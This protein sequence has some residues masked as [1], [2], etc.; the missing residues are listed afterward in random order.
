MKNN[1]KN[2][3]DAETLLCLLKMS[4]ESIKNGKAIPIRKAFKDL[5]EKI[6]KFNLEQLSKKGT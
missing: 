4:E 2:M 3:T 5:D 1:I 6:K